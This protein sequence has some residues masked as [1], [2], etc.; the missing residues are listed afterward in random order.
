M[1]G[2]MEAASIWGDADDVIAELNRADEPRRRREAHAKATRR[3]G[4]RI[5]L[6]EQTSR[7]TF[8]MPLRELDREAAK[9]LPPRHELEAALEA[10]RTVAGYDPDQAA[11]DN[12][13]GFARSDVPLGHPLASAPLSSPS[14][15]RASRCSCGVWHFTTAARCL[16]G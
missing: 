12:N 5:A 1:E 11:L 9:T 4:G 6:A 2:V 7:A 15:A 10:V 14:T 13:V 8:G 3:R 16:P